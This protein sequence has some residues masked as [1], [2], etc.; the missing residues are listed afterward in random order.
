[1]GRGGGEGTKGW[2]KKDQLCVK[3]MAEKS[4]LQVSSLPSAA[5]R[6]HGRGHQGTQVTQ[7]YWQVAAHAVACRQQWFPSL[8]L[9]PRMCDGAT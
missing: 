9:P 7:K 5:G 8:P 4:T 6:G 2:D 1:M 3:S